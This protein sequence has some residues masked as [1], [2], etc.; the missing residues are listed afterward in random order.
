MSEAA[1]REG[2]NETEGGREG[3]R[4]GRGGR[5]EV[6]G[7]D[8]FRLK[9][10]DKKKCEGHVCYKRLRWVIMICVCLRGQQD[11]FLFSHCGG[12]PAAERKRAYK[13]EKLAE[14]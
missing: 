4:R 8:C 7:L 6:I 2:E 12:S 10:C 1:E 14:R 5:W 11:P 13:S 3:G 9:C